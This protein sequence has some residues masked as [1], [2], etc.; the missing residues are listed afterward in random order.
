MARCGPH[1]QTVSSVFRAIR[2]R[3]SA[4]RKGW[5]R[6]P[7][8]PS[9]RALTEPFGWEPQRFGVVDGMRG[10]SDFSYGASSAWQGRDNKLYF[11]TYGGMLEIDPVRLSIRRPAPPALIERVSDDRQKAVAAGGWVRAGSNLEFHY[12]AL[13]FLFPEFI[14]FRYRLERFAP[15]WVEAGKRRAAYYRNFPP[16]AYRFRVAARNMDGAWNESGAPFPLE[17]RPRFYQTP[18]FA[19]LCLAAAALGFAFY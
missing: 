7:E 19:A 10:S 18:W 15:E 12:T 16:G 1:R 3:A 8:Q 4:K 5:P 14:Q 11:A 13:S 17:A 9:P 6:C 2:W